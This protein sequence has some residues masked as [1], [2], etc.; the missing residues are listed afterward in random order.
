[1]TTTEIRDTGTDAGPPDEASAV[2]IRRRK[3]TMSACLGLTF[4]VAM[5]F[6]IANETQAN[7]Q[8]DQAHAA[9][10][11]T[12]VQVIVATRD[13]TAVRRALADVDGQVSVD[14]TTLTD[15]ASK[16]AGAKSALVTAQADV[17]R[18]A[19]AE[20][21]LHACLGGVEQALNA[22][23]VGDQNRAVRAL[24][25]VASGCTSAGVDVG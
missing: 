19:T 14:A 9:L 22:L 12:R 8:F 25:A 3:W 18:Q 13:L 11:A 24:D 4:V 21:G 17:A 10:D 15:D 2:G 7:T 16:L 23:A 5:G 6:L 20:S 1:M